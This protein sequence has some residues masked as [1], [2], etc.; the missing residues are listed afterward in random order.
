MS[1]PTPASHFD[2]V[3]RF[4]V[5]RGARSAALVSPGASN[6][7][8]TSFAMDSDISSELNE[9]HALEFQSHF[10]DQRQVQHP[11]AVTLRG[12][13]PSDRMRLPARQSFDG[14]PEQLLYGLFERPNKNVRYVSRQHWSPT[15]SQQVPQH[16]HRFIGDATRRAQET[17]CP[18][19]A[20]HL[21]ISY[22]RRFHLQCE[23]D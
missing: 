21:C 23:N 5:L 8:V 15:N 6:A 2:I 12:A 18:I 9:T 20:C 11:K 4:P 10:M 1:S 22:I 3:R 13:V 14:V 16:L 7:A 17:Y 19:I